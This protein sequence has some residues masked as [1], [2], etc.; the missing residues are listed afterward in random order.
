MNFHV[1]ENGTPTQSLY[2]TFEQALVGTRLYLE[3]ESDIEI[4]TINN[5]SPVKVWKFD[6]RYGQFIEQSHSPYQP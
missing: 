3:S 4:R 6:Y 1:Y 2:E 5:I